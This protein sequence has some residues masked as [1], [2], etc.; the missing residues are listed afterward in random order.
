MTCDSLPKSH[1]NK[2][3]PGK[4]PFSF[5]ILFPARADR[6]AYD[7][8]LIETELS[9]EEARRRFHIHDRARRFADSPDFSTK[10]R[11]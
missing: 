7:L 6:L 2:L 8:G 10:I 1:V 3:L 5:S 11:Q 4:V 9:F